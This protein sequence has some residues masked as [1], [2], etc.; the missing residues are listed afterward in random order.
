MR[1]PECACSSAAGGG[2][3]SALGIYNRHDTVL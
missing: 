2:F 3:A 1:F